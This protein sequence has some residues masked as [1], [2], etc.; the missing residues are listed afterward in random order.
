[1]GWRLFRY[2][3][4]DDRYFVYLSGK[5][6]V[7]FADSVTGK[8]RRLNL[9]ASS[10]FGEPRDLSYSRVG[11]RLAVAGGSEVLIYDIGARSR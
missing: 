5:D 1:M 10:S 3:W 2:E 4:L 8:Q 9:P 6:G 7:Y 11:G